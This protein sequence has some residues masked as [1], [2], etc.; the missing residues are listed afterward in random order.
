MG[1]F[2]KIKNVLKKTK[3][4]LITKL[5]AVFRGGDIDADFYEEHKYDETLLD[6][7]QE[8]TE[9]KKTSDDDVNLKKLLAENKALKEELTARREEQHQTYVP[10]PLDLSEYKTRKIY[11]DSMLNDAGWTEGKDWINEVE[12][13]GDGIWRILSFLG[14]ILGRVY[15]FVEVKKVTVECRRLYEHQIMC[16]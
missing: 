5:N 8:P 3:D 14:T 15:R 13:P 11:I 10:K 6:K 12:I 2:S 9:V 1:R 16:W 7:L 4:A